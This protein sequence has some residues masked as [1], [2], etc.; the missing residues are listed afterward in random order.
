MLS[1]YSGCDYADWK[2]TVIKNFRK[3]APKKVD[4]STLVTSLTFGFSAWHFIWK[5]LSCLLKWNWPITSSSWGISNCNSQAPRDPL[6]NSEWA[7]NEAWK[8]KYR[9]SVR[10][11]WN[12]YFDPF[13]SKWTSGF[14]LQRMGKWSRIRLLITNGSFYDNLWRDNW[15][16]NTCSAFN[17]YNIMSFIYSLCTLRKLKLFFFSANSQKRWIRS[18]YI[19]QWPKSWP[20]IQFSAQTWP[21]LIF[22]RL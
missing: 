4:Y 19:S 15:R 18:W 6:F 16:N 9:S 17:D 3:E 5:D 12:A 7:K 10:R 8:Y 11:Q 21:T 2:W 22:W 20:F 1:S 14:L 13:L